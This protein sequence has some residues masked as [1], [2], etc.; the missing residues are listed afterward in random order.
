MKLSI[1]IP[2]FHEE[3]NIDKTLSRIEKNVHIPHEALI[4]YDDL[5]DPTYDVVK[6]YQRKHKKESLLIIPNNTGSKHGVM[7]AIKTG[8]AHS[9][10][11]AIIV[12]MA[13]LADDI[14]QI[15]SMYDIFTHGF[16]IVCASRYMKGGKKIGG[17]FLKTVLSRLA[18]LTLFYFLNIPTHD[19]TNAF[20]L[21]NRKIFDNIKIESTGG[22]EYSLEIILKA[23]ALGYQ[24]TE[25]PTIWKDRVSGSSNFKILFWLPNYMKLYLKAY[26]LLPKMTF[27]L[28]NKRRK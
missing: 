11:N 25:I 23:H 20:K 7:N 5:S 15:D 17:P 26:Q 16:D 1:I 6:S 13:D 21:Y 27:S 28:F 18:G 22:F 3:K 19:A 4:V 2:V 9:H 24:I 10:G 12:L 8:F 14:S